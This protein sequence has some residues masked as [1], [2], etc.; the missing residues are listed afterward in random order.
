MVSPRRRG[1]ECP[2]SLWVHPARPLIQRKRGR[3]TPPPR[4]GFTGFRLRRFS[5]EVRLPSGRA[6]RAGTR[7]SLERL[8]HPRIHVP[9]EDIERNGAAT[10]H[11]VM[12]GLDVE[13]VAQP[14][15]RL[16]AQFLDLQ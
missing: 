15:L 7:A 16:L 8:V 5:F 9:L 6:A 12:E 13:L 10:K 3:S 1:P 4:L 2:I 14:L 11:R